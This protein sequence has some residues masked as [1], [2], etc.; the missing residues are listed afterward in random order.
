MESQDLGLAVVG[1]LMLVLGLFAGMLQSRLYVLS[2]PL[3][4]GSI[5][6]HGVRSAWLT[7]WYGDTSVDE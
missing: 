6:V 7:L 3:V 5:L 2:D 4:A 1:S